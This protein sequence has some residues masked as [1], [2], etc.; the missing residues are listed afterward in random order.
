MSD[1]AGL[2]R[3]KL[4]AA[5]NP[6]RLEL[7]DESSRHVGHAGNIAGGGHYNVTIV[8]SAFA[9]KTPIQ[10]HRMVYDALGEMMREEIHAL[11]IKALTPDQKGS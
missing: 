8:S 1:R 9:G 4:T 7:S 11:S 10:R 2:I 3:Q 6:E 5:F